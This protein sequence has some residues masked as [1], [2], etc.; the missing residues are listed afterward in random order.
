MAEAQGQLDCDGEIS[1]FWIEL[2]TIQPFLQ[3]TFRVE[4]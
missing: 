4:E 1:F 2:P 3:V